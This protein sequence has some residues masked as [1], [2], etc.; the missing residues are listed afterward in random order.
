VVPA[1]NNPSFAHA[2]HDIDLGI[3][4]EGVQLLQD[5]R[6]QH[7]ITE[8]GGLDDEEPLHPSILF[9]GDQHFVYTVAVHVQ[10][11]GCETIR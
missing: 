1:P 10:Y 11:F 3:G 2:H 8:K 7:G 6:H 5:A 9:Q 4:V